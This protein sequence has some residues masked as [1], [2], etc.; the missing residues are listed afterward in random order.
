MAM[1]IE[2]AGI[3][4]SAI[5]R[6]LNNKMVNSIRNLFVKNIFVKQ[7]KRSNGVRE[8]LKYFTGC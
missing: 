7:I 8:A 3:N 6:P 1:V 4:L 5:Y 2:K